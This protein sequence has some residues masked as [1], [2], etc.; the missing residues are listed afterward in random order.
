MNEKSDDGWY[1]GE[2][3]NLARRVVA[4]VTDCSAWESDIPADQW[5]VGEFENL[6]RRA[7]APVT[8]CSDWDRLPAAWVEVRGDGAAALVAAAPALKLVHDPARSHTD[9]TGAVV[10]LAAADPATTREELAALI[11]A[12]RAALGPGT[13]ADIRLCPA[14]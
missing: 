13:A 6:V 3:E 4:P 12:I 14:A 5:T 9:A 10:A 7:V 1:H 11:P 2:F 8:D